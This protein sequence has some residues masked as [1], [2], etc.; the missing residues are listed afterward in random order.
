MTNTTSTTI[1]RSASNVR[2]EQ[3]LESLAQK[4]EE[5]IIPD[6]GEIKLQT[7]LTNG[8]VTS[9]ESW[10]NRA[11]GFCACLSVL[12]VPVLLA[13]IIHYVAKA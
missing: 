4:V 6:I 10:R 13:V 9:L 8:R 12:A 3:A 7:K 1:R 5:V 2:L 11:I